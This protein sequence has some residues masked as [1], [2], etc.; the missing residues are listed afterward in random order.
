MNFQ[1]TLFNGHNKTK[2][3]NKNNHTYISKYL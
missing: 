3:F 1:L 2:A